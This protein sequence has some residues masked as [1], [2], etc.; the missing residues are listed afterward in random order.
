MQSSI[1]KNKY[2]LD[3]N[4]TPNSSIWLSHPFDKI[5]ISLWESVTHKGEITTN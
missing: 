5:F 3:L 1:T 2:T 4:S